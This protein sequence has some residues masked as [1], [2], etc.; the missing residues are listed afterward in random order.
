M[1]GFKT[2]NDGRTVSPGDRV[3]VPPLTLEVGGAAETVNVP[4]KSPQ[5]QS[6]HR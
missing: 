6:Q 4:A 5:I 2:L 1:T 3:A